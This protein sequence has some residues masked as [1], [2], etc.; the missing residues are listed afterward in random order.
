[1][2]IDEGLSFKEGSSVKMVFRP[3]DVFLRR[4]ENLTQK[5][6]KLT[7][8]TVQEVSFVGAFERVTVAVDLPGKDSIIVIRPKTE[9]AAFP[10]APGQTVPV[11]LVRFCIIGEPQRPT[12][13]YRATA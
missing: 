5:Y 2:H 11:G 3:E 9:T 7:Q 8:G 10:L 4:P 6:E 12:A 1:M 13:R